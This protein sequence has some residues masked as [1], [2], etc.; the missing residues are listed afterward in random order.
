MRL[1]LFVHSTTT[2]HLQICVYRKTRIDCRVVVSPIRILTASVPWATFSIGSPF[3]SLLFPSEV[4]HIDVRFIFRASSARGP[5]IS[6]R[7][8]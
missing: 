2:L 4:D 8:M 6:L 1:S 5:C 7:K 3:R